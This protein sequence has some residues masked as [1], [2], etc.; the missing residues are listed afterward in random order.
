MSYIFV[1]YNF[2]SHVNKGD[3]GIFTVINSLGP[4]GTWATRGVTIFRFLGRADALGPSEI[5]A[6]TGSVP[7]G[8]TASARMAAVRP[9]GPF[10][11]YPV[12]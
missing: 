6:E 1:T 7:K 2:S 8:A 10:A 5:R 12:D 9:L 11:E 3:R 4:C